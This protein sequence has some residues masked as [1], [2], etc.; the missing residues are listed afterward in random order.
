MNAAYATASLWPKKRRKFTRTAAHVATSS[1]RSPRP[2]GENLR[3]AD[4]TTGFKGEDLDN[5][6][7][8]FMSGLQS[9]GP[10]LGAVEIGQAGEEIRARY[11][12]VAEELLGPDKAEAYIAEL[13]DGDAERSRRFLEE[14]VKGAT[15]DEALRAGGIVE[16]P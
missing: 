3:L 11:A 2:L 5:F 1:R 16:N 9:F 14:Y 10:V 6:H 4:E 8:A 12:V 15:A 7:E 13:F